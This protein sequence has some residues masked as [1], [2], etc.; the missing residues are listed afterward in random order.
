MQT[1]AGEG[2]RFQFSSDQSLLLYFDVV[3]SEDRAAD[4]VGTSSARPLQD[5]EKHWSED[6]PLQR[7]FTLQANENVRKLLRLLELEPV[8]SIRNLHPAYCSLLIKFDALR[9]QHEELEAILRE[10]LDRKSTRL[11]SSHGYIS[12][13]VFCLKKK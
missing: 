9:M 6:R 4:P 5:Q 12:Y 8:K 1:S 3:E 13:A 10:Y 11:N 2:A 7:Q